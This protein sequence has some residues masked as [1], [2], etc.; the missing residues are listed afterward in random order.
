MRYASILIS[1]LTAFFPQQYNP[2]NVTL[3][4][5]QSLGTI[6]FP[7]LSVAVLA[8]AID[9]IARVWFRVWRRYESWKE[10]ENKE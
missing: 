8:D 5:W 2:D 3:E 10:I 4:N 9:S 7:D 6:S 1:L